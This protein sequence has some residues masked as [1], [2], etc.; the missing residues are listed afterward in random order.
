MRYVAAILATF[1][2]SSCI[3]TRPIKQVDI[4]HSTTWLESS[5]DN[6]II[7]VMQ[8][9]YANDDVEIV[10]KKKLTTDYV[11]IML[12]NGRKV[13]RKETVLNNG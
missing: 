13:I 9:E 10:I 6:P 5:S 8:Y 2:L 3:V 4:T 12:R 1:L 7:N 11:K